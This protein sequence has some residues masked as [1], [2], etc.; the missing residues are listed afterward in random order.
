MAEAQQSKGAG[1]VCFDEENI[2][3]TYHPA[4]KDY[5]HMKIDEPNTPYEQPLP[6]DDEAEDMPDLQMDAGEPEPN[7][8]APADDWIDDAEH[9]PKPVHTAE[10]HAKFEKMRKQHYNMKEAMMRAKRLL[11][12]EDEEDD[13]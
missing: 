2:K 10:E 12:K 4:D 9:A 6:S 11:A 5:G 7:A 1:H 13:E 8:A 3:A